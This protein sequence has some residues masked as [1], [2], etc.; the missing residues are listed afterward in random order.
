MRGVSYKMPKTPKTK[1]E[2]PEP[3]KEDA[4][5]VKCWGELKKALKEKGIKLN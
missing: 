1:L 2:E 5:L 4:F 3:G